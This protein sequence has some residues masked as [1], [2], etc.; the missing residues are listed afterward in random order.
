MVTSYIQHTREQPD[1]S[2]YNIMVMLS[3]MSEAQGFNIGFFHSITCTWH[4]SYNEQQ[5]YILLY[6]HPCS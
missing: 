5:L 1:S 3:I 6:G 4:Y 2:V